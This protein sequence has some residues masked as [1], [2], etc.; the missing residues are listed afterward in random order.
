MNNIQAKYLK[1]EDG[2]VVSPVA[3]ADSVFITYSS[4]NIL[5]GNETSKSV[6]QNLEEDILHNK[7]VQYLTDGYLY[8]KDVSN[9]NA[10]AI[11]KD[12]T[13]DT[14]N[15]H[16]YFGLGAPG[17]QGSVYTEIYK[18]NVLQNRWDFK[19][20]GYIYDNNNVKFL[21]DTS[22]I[23]WQ[24]AGSFMSGSQSA[25]L[26]DTVSNQNSGICL[27]WSAYSG[28][29]GKDWFWQSFF[30]PKVLV[31]NKTGCGYS[32]FLCG[33]ISNMAYKYCYIHNNKIA[34]N[35]NNI[36]SGTVNGIPYNNKNFVLRYVIGV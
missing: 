18:N 33:G 2:Q 31:S 8:V 16:L 4:P 30:I 5:I 20:D 28:S 22:K 9:N 26:N 10:V 23:L 3:D 32:M 12:R 11:R 36:E 24:D 35:D 13:I 15:Y 29:E 25:N 7:G 14:N 17:G 19:I 21:K 1:D 6:K 34:G 27:V